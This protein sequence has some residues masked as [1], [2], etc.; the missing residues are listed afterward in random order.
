MILTKSKTTTMIDSEKKIILDADVIIHFC[1]G[2]LLGKLPSI[3]PNKLFIPSIVYKEALS[4]KHATEVSN[5]LSFKLATELEIKYDKKVF[6]EYN[7]L[8]KSGLGKGES[9]C[10]AYCRYNNDV[11]GSSNLKDIKKYCTDNGI[12]YLTTMDFINAAFEGE[13]L[14]ESECD[15]FIYNVI[16]KGSRLPFKTLNEYRKSI[17]KA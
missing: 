14:T 9:A 2:N 6:I 8:L 17:K 16:S 12:T 7:R 10:M 15:E 1:K 4:K 3:Y 13:I 11:I 5:L